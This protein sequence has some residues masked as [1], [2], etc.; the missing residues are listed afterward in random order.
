MTWAQNDICSARRV[1]WLYRLVLR[2][3]QLWRAPHEAGLHIGSPVQAPCRSTAQSKQG[4]LLRCGCSGHRRCLEERPL[5]AECRPT[6]STC[7][8]H[9]E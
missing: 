2:G 7:S 9:R 4:H 1:T 3:L 6:R 8:K 5:C